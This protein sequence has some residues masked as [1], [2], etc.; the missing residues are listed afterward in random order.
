MYIRKLTYKHIKRKFHGTSVYVWV[1]AESI[2]WKMWY[3]DWLRFRE[4]WQLVQIYLLY[5]RTTISV[6]R[7]YIAPHSIWSESSLHSVYM[8]HIH[9]CM[10]P[11]WTLLFT[12]HLFVNTSVIIWLMR[13]DKCYNASCLSKRIKHLL[14]VCRTYRRWLCIVL[15]KNFVRCVNIT[16]IMSK[17]KYLGRSTR[18]YCDLSRSQEYICFPLHL[19]HA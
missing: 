19:L 17:W 18:S 13:V 1:C 10:H 6:N 14:H 3:L 11:N 16:S 9:T 4:S 2:N 5:R 8:I 15:F 12:I 7:T